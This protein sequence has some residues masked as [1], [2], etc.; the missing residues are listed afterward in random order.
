MTNIKKIKEPVVS[1]ALFFHLFNFV[2]QTQ[3]VL[4]FF[5]SLI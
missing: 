4:S 1:P 5:L 2:I 3:V